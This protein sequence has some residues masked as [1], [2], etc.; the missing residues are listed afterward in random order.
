MRILFIYPQHYLFKGIPLGI[1]ILSAIL[2]KQGHIVSLFDTTFMKGEKQKRDKLNFD[3]YQ[4]KKAPTLSYDDKLVDIEKKLLE[5]INDF[6]PD[7]IAFSITTDL[8]YRTRQLIHIIN[9]NTS[10][11]PI[12]VGGVHPTINPKGVIPFVDFICVGEGEEAIPELCEKLGKG[13][14][15]KHIKNIWYNDDKKIYKNDLRPLVNL[16]E[17]P[18]PDWSLFDKRHLE[19]IY[20]GKIVNRGHYIGMRGCP[21]QCSYCT[22]NYL[23]KLFKGKGKYVRWESV[24]K[25][26][27]NLKKLKE[28]Y[29][30][31]NIKFSDD[32]F[33]ASPLKELEHFAREYKKHINIPFLISVSPALVTEDKIRV[34]KY[35][36]CIHHSIGIETANNYIR[37]NVLKRTVTNE[38]IIN[39]F[40]I[41]HKLNIRTSA[42][43]MIGLPTETRKDIFKTI[44]MNRECKVDTV[45]VYYIYPY[46]KTEILE[47]CKTLSEASVAESY[48]FNMS[49]IS[50][51]RLR[52][53]KKTFVLYLKLPKGF[54]P[55][56]R[57]C[58]Y[59]NPISNW[60]TKKMFMYMQRKAIN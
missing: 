9:W 52:G 15:I 23:K 54:Y 39:T 42:F 28:E 59:N 11:I 3:A 25:T 5:K 12:I 48:K 37:K 16:N 47:H 33:I 1:S 46:P 18:C 7:L 44:K 29:K 41:A 20:R 34:L 13:E 27:Q 4:F 40:N 17:I 57:L 21:Y 19:G 38:Q 45:N 14:D 10:K 43:N 31:D 6:S 32:L 8:W 51:R 58:E 30:L 36:G 50:T 2:K 35:A 55:I 56:I 26:V 22:N 60:I 24:D 49:E 53:L